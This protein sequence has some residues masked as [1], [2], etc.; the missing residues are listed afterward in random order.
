MNHPMRGHRT[1]RIL[2]TRRMKLQ[3][4]H[5]QRPLNLTC[6]PKSPLEH[7][8][9]LAERGAPNKAWCGA[10]NNFQTSCFT[11]LQF[12]Q[13]LTC[14]RALKD[15]QSLA[16]FTAL[17]I[18][19]TSGAV[20]YK[21]KSHRLGFMLSGCCF[22][23]H[24]FVVSNIPVLHPIQHYHNIHL[25]IITWFHWIKT[26]SRLACLKCKHHLDRQLAC[27]SSLGSASSAH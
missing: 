10:L 14:C 17:K 18:W 3:V 12:W 2:W 11:A 15:W 21:R 23:V 24:M 7:R 20:K 22:C 19:T 26:P 13:I 16:W 4:H 25:L 27:W 8:Q 9:S 5:C 1:Q 6:K